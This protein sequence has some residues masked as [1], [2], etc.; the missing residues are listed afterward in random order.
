MAP[1]YHYLKREVFF[2]VPNLQGKSYF[3]VLII[4]FFTEGNG[5]FFNSIRRV[6]YVF[7]ILLMF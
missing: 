6:S 3:S 4:L 1:K 2:S 7:N 5:D